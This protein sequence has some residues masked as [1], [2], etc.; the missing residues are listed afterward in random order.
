M[1]KRIKAL[2]LDF[3]K[4]PSKLSIPKKLTKNYD[5]KAPLVVSKVE[6]ELTIG[7]TIDIIDFTIHLVNV[8]ISIVKSG[9]VLGLVTNIVGI[10][11]LIPKLINAITGIS[12]VPMELKTL[13]IKQKD[14]IIKQ[15]KEGMEFNG[16]AKATIELIIDVAF[17]LAILIKKIF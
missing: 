10:G 3:T 8:L 13:T 6:T 14:Q 1:D 9:V 2:D 7:E 11:K 12:K 16:E 15:I 17:G 5:A 4:I